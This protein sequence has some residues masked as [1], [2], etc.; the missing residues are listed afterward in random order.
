MVADGGDL[1]VRA[2]RMA[3]RV[4]KD[5]GCPVADGCGLAVWCQVCNKI[6][7]LARPFELQNWTKHVESNMHKQAVEKR[8]DEMVNWDMC[9]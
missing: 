7:P 9:A 8:Q 3:A 5:H 1:T 6:Q 4:D 2:A